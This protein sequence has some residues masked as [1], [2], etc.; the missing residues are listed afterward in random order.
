MEIHFIKWLFFRAADCQL[1]GNLIPESCLAIHKLNH[2]SFVCI[3]L[4]R[5]LQRKEIDVNIV[6]FIAFLK[7]ISV[8]SEWISTGV[9]YQAC[10]GK[11]TGLSEFSVGMTPKRKFFAMMTMQ[12]KCAFFAFFLNRNV[13]IL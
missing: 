3:C 8:I 7:S 12:R 6:M 4:E 5:P 13:P 2:K 9:G 1:S 11:F 10:R